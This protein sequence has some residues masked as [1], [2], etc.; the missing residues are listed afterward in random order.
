MRK[1][2][3]KSEKMLRKKPA[4]RDRNEPRNVKPAPGPM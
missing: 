3:K 4:K 2:H 1:G